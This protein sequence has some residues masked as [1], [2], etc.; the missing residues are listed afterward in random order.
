MGKTVFLR[1]IE[2]AASAT[3]DL[4]IL[5]FSSAP[6]ELSSRSCLEALAQGLFGEAAAADGFLTPG[7]LLDSYFQ[8]SGVPGTLILLYDEFDS[9]AESFP[10][11]SA[12][13]APGRNF[14]NGLEAARRE[15]PMGVLA[16]GGIGTF[17]FRDVL[18]SPFLSRATP[19]FL[20]P[21]THEDLRVLSQPFTER[22][23]ILPDD[24]LD[25]ILLASGGNPLLVT[26]GLERLWEE[27]LATGEKIPVFFA[28]FQDKHLQFLLSFERSFSYERLSGAPQRVLELVRSKGR[29]LHQAELLAACRQF[30][31]PLDLE[32][33][34]VVQLLRAAGLVRLVGS[35]N[36]DRVVLEPIASILNLEAQPSVSTSFRERFLED[37]ETQLAR[38]HSLSAD[39][40]RPGTGGSGKQLV[41]EATFSAVLSMGFQNLGWRVER[42][43]QYGAGRTDLKLGLADTDDLALVEVKIWGR[44]DYAEVHGQLA[45]YWSH[46]VTAGAVVMLTDQTVEGERYRSVCLEPHGIEAPLVETPDLPIQA[47]FT[48]PTT[49][50]DGSEVRID[51]F[52]LRL[53]RRH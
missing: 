40:F 34:E 39:F 29:P 36:A 43:A 51:H 45:S 27:N 44:N 11:S 28:E 41:P 23:Q 22:G 31:D 9:Y 8:S 25:L 42:E 7:Q 6:Q 13:Q 12:E 17:I 26:Y 47:R 37:L 30:D 18:G 20:D 2:A 50:D 35:T 16:A 33:G 38:L 32:V 15:Y 48:C 21:F 53:R 5:R 52:L 4:R 24:V 1:Q 10:R 46:R 14:F 19:V 3:A 49:L